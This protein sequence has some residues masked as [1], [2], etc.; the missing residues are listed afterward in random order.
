[1]AGGQPKHK[2]LAR[3]I[4]KALGGPKRLAVIKIAAHTRDKSLHGI[5]NKG[6]D[7]AAK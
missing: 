6:A 4:L 5:G 2:D 1:M 7:R 3:G